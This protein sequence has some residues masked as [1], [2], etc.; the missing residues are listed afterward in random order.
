MARYRR[1]SVPARNTEMEG[2]NALDAEGG[3]ERGW[4]E[5][6]EEDL[7]EGAS[8]CRENGQEE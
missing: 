5:G 7:E 3:E 6:A 4:K 1:S 2:I 8:E